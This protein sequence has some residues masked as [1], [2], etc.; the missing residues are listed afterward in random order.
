MSPAETILRRILARTDR[1][2]RIRRLLIAFIFPE[3]H[4]ILGDLSELSD[5]LKL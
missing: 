2:G 4:D 5:H 3:F 1:P